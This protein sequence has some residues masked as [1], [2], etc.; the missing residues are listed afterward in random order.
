MPLIGSDSKPLMIKG[1]TKHKQLGL[2]G[3]FFKPENKKKFD[4]NWDIIFGKKEF[5]AKSKAQ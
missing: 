4:D 5:K 3:K 2:T 1:N